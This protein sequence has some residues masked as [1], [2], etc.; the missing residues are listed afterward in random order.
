MSADATRDARRPP[1]GPAIVTARLEIS[2]ATGALVEAALQGREQLAAGLGAVV[3]DAWPPEHLDEAALRFTLER[4]S[5]GADHAGWWLHFVVLTER[6]APRTLVGA[7]GYAGPPSRDGTVEIGYGILQEFRRRGLATEVVHGLVRHAFGR[8]SVRR[9]IAETY[10]GLVASR[11]VLAKA[12]FHEVRESS[13]AGV[14]RYEL[15]RAHP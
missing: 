2:P 7:A 15:R 10:P 5:E 3:P 11:A 8:P 4:L 13:A 12:G 9:V 14:L 1:T 6:P